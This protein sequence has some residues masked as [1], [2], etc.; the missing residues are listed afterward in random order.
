MN[1]VINSLL[2]D[3]RS[4]KKISLRQLEAL[5]GISK[6]QISDVEN[7]TSIPTIYTLCL[8]AVAL[9]VQPEELY[10]YKVI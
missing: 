10:T 3:V 4:Q 2:K 1:I 9:D 7:E 8:L 5:S 6:S